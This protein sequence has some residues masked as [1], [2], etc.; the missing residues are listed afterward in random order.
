VLEEVC[1]SRH[2]ERLVSLSVDD[3]KI[4]DRG[5]EM[6]AASQHAQRLAKLVLVRT[7]I[8]RA[9]VEALAAS[10]NL[11]SLRVVDGLP[12]GFFETTW[13]DQGQIINVI[14]PPDAAEIEAK[15]G[16]Q[17]WLHP[18][19]ETQWRGVRERAL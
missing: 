2:L 7:G 11:P 15:Y 6:I 9:G 8:T 17:R 13:F 1:N 3:E 18:L 12:E 19:E 10:S 5:V 4:G 14:R 16:Y